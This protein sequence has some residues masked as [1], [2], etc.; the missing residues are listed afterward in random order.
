M[1]DEP[2][3]YDSVVKFIEQV[4]IKNKEYCVSIA[5]QTLDHTGHVPVTYNVARGAGYCAYY[6]RLTEA[7][8]VKDSIPYR[9]PG[10]GRDIH[11]VLGL[12]SIYL[13]KD[14]ILPPLTHKIDES[15]NNAINILTE[16][17]L[18]GNINNTDRNVI[19]Q[20]LRNLVSL[21][22]RALMN[23]DSN[24]HPFSPIPEQQL[25]DYSLHMRG[26][27]D[28]ILENKEQSKAIVIDWKTAPETPT[29]REA[30]QVICYAL[31]ESRR[32][33]YDREEAIKGLVGELDPQNNTIKNL[34][35]LPLIIR[36]TTTA[37][38]PRPH[39]VFSGLQGDDLESEYKK[40]RNLVYDVLVEAEHLTILTTN[41]EEILGEK[42]VAVKKRCVAT[43][44]DGHQVYSLR[45]TPHQLRRGK[46]SLQQNYPCT[47]CNSRVRDA[48]R[49]YFGR[50]IGEASDLDK[51]LWN[52]RFKVFQKLERDLI[53]YKAIYELFN[54]NGFDVASEMITSRSHIFWDIGSVPVTHEKTPIPIL[55]IY[56]R[57]T[58]LQSV[59][60][61]LLDTLQ[62]NPNDRFEFTG[63]R[64]LQDYE[65][66]SIIRH[67]PEGRTILISFNDSSTP[68]LSFN[69][70][71][72]IREVDVDEKNDA[73]QYTIG[74]PSNVLA[75]SF[76]L[77]DECL[78]SNLIKNGPIVMFEVGANLIHLELNAI[79]QLQRAFSKELEEQT[80]PD[81][82]Q[83][84]Q[85]AS[86]LVNEV[87]EE[88]QRL[89]EDTGTN[90]ITK[91]LAD[92]ISRG[93]W[94][95]TKGGS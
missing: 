37:A 74:L 45:Y 24:N 38:G 67:V 78:K 84:L 10:K 83:A 63:T 90:S 34:N 77:I 43:T 29:I 13:F 55:D 70:F 27:P 92:V 76:L 1:S 61:D 47:I 52:L 36:P 95:A 19:L 56:R 94:R 6:A 18:I 15:V 91:I 20:M 2:A 75:Y 12:S 41:I 44:R 89:E 32:L 50:A 53:V 87:K 28:L 26:V 58:R 23:L 49:F 4:S 33:G 85:Q 65:K 60:Y 14:G 17:N 11:K 62:T 39:P 57:G 82:R 21:L 73:V 86:N 71:G 40:F 7:I 25:I 69:L 51:T 79:D 59:R 66:E 68:T 16:M 8:G 81:S 3:H 88:M 9:I 22:D 42:S 72:I 93:K 35:V 5:R 31:L 80:D 64:K 30:A 54:K 46:P 48:C